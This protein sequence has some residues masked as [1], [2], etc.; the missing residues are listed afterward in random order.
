M[1]VLTFKFT[2]AFAL[3]LT[4]CNSFKNQRLL[5]HLTFDDGEE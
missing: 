1:D 3:S 2:K 5:T 4:A